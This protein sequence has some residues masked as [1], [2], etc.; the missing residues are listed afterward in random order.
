VV[1]VALV[2]AGVG[3][4]IVAR[5]PH[6]AL[7]RLFVVDGLLLAVVVFTGV[8][9]YHAIVAEPGSLPAGRWA[10]W[11]T[12]ALY[13]P[14]FAC[15]AVLLF[16]L[17]PD[18][19]LRTRAERRL[20][21]LTAAGVVVGLVGT[22]I[23]PA[24]YGYGLPTPA[25][26]AVPEDAFEAVA[27]VA[28][29]LVVSALVGAVILLVR[30][31]RRAVGVEREQLRILVWAS[32]V[33]MLL[34]VPAFFL[35]GVFPT[36][37]YLIGG[38]GILLIPASVGVAIL[39]HGLLDI[40]LVI[41]RTVVVGLLGAFITLVYVGVVVGVGAAVGNR[42]SP[43]LSAG[44]AAVVAL[45]FQPV[46]RGARRVADR[47]VYGERATPY[48]VLS[49]L[50]ARMGETYAADDLLPRIARIL[51]EGTGALG[52]SVWLHVGGEV[53][54]AAVWPPDRERAD[55]IPVVDATLPRLP[56]ERAV[57]V[58]HH[59]ELLGAL[60]I[61]KPPDDPLT[62][63]EERL[64]DDV[65]AQS[66]LALRNVRLT[67]ELREKVEELRR[68]RQ[69]LV[70][71]Q[72][73]ERRKLER[74][75]H[76]GA[77]Q[78]LVALAVKTRMVDQL[79]D[80]DTARAHE[81]LGSLQ[82]ET[83]ETLEELRDLARGIYPPLLAEQGLASAV[84]AQARKAPVEVHV[85]ADGI[86]RF[87]REV[88]ST[89]YFCV[90]ES[91]QNAA[92]HAGGSPVA[93]SLL[94]SDGELRFE[95]RDDGPGFDPATTRRGA[96]LQN[97]ADRLDAVGGSFELTSAPGRGTVLVGRIPVAAMPS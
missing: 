92:K 76:D 11:I 50:A 77:Q 86:P 79:L 34:F 30:R 42:T 53:R 51:A 4:A 39:R 22:A 91:L 7:G 23:E 84:V 46:R 24:L 2:Y 94:A 89:V 20:A 17:F 85:E 40:D 81:M 48:E 27:A 44:A 95:V 47:L 67:E 72:D 10:A 66:A 28:A 78:R 29:A 19:R 73:D 31:L 61:D 38:L 9:G 37:A 71:A 90:L 33:G 36:F 18:G 68:S 26:S 8:Y 35:P 13:V 69:R 56:H 60:A 55:P 88:E 12:D 6:N 87:P 75:I 45:A 43:V 15:F 62:A 59:G 96:G 64:L 74:N 63:T 57:A 5:R 3:A 52:T 54:P 49:T 41:R 70:K 65:A 97:M 21:L 58:E 80:R 82:A 32:F 1:V 16:L 25:R 93:V 83:Q 14:L